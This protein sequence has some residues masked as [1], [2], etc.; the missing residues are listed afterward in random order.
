[1]LTS[2]DITF[3]S[4][5][6]MSLVDLNTYKLIFLNKNEAAMLCLLLFMSVEHF[7]HLGPV[8]LRLVVLPTKGD[9]Y[10]K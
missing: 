7:K 6:T 4:V 10:L 8:Q 9:V 1:M 3:N 2:Y 5:H